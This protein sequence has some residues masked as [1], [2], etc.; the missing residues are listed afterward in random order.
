MPNNALAPTAQL[1]RSQSAAELRRD[2]AAT[3]GK[4]MRTI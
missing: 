3:I 1:L 4:G 2:A